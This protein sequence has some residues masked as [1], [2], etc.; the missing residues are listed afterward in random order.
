MGKRVERGGDKVLENAFCHIRGT[1]ARTGRHL[2]RA[3]VG[4]WEA[5]Q[6]VLPLPPHKAEPVKQ[7]AEESIARLAEQGANRC[8]TCSTS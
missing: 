8:H 1:G 4:S 3:G 2:W 7:G 6:G 5:A